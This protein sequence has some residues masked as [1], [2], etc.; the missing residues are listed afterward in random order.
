MNNEETVSQLI[1]ITWQ[2][3]ILWPEQL[4]AVYGALEFIAPDKFKDLSRMQVGEISRHLGRIE[5]G[6]VWK[7][8]HFRLITEQRQGLKSAIEYLEQLENNNLDAEK[9]RYD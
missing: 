3:G 5:K 6:V 9:G 4:T 8:H 2:Q 7:P 1:S